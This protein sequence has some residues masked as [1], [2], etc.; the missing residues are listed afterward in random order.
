MLWNTQP[1]N[2]FMITFAGVALSEYLFPFITGNA[3]KSFGKMRLCFCAVYL[4]VLPSSC[5]PA[6]NLFC[7]VGRKG[8]THEDFSRPHYL[9]NSSFQKHHGVYPY[10]FHFY[11][12]VHAQGG[13]GNYLCGPR[14]ERERE[15]K[16][17]RDRDRDR[18][19]AGERQ[20]WRQTLSQIT[21]GRS[22]RDMRWTN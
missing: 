10:I 16:E 3:F 5:R 22:Q 21:Q 15:I 2:I 19:T 14:R 8:G 9:W 18:H 6:E 1:C 4:L 11:C 7:L 20:L 12:S 17:K 13:N